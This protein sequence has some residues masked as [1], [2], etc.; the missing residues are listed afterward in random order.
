MMRQ[1]G[2]CAVGEISTR[3]RFFSRAFLSASNGAMVPSCSPASSITRTSRARMRSFMRIKRLSILGLL[4]REKL[5]DYNRNAAAHASR[6][7]EFHVQQ[8]PQRRRDAKKLRLGI[9]V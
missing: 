8:L 2:G 6:N 3:S 7:T 4:E 5:P 9:W 1:T